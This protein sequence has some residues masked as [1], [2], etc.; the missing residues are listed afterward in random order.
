MEGARLCERL[1]VLKNS[2][3]AATSLRSGE[4]SDEFFFLFLSGDWQ[5]HCR[6]AEEAHQSLD[7]LRSRGQKEL[8]SNEPHAP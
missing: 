7:I 2:L 1:W 3:I 6:F 4:G 5:W 8:L